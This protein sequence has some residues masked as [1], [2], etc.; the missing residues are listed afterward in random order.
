MSTRLTLRARN[1][2]DA[3]QAHL[4]THPLASNNCKPIKVLQQSEVIR[5]AQG[6]MV[7]LTLECLG[8][9]DCAA[10]PLGLIDYVPIS[11]LHA[12]WASMASHSLWTAKGDGGAFALVCVEETG[13]L[14]SNGNRAVNPLSM[15]SARAMLPYYSHVCCSPTHCRMYG[16]CTA[17]VKACTW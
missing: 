11:P 17:S 13:A 12:G 9:T 4:S 16:F 14:C 1:L 2:K 5:N 8:P 10:Q 7:N 6:R 3:R 15:S